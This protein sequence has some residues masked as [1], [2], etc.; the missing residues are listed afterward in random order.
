[1]KL[2]LLPSDGGDCIMVEAGGVAILADGGMFGSYKDEVRAFLGGFGKPL[3]LV[4]VSHVDEDH[5]AGVLQMLEDMVAWRVHKHKKLTNP[6]AKAPAF[7]E[8]PAVKRIWHNA[9]KAMVDN[10]GDV[11]T[12]LA[13]SANTLRSAPSPALL[14]LGLAYR[15]IANSIPQAVKVSRRIASDQLNIPLNGEF[16]GL[17][18]MVRED[19]V[20]KLKS[21]GKLKIR[22][23]GPF[24]EDLEVLRD[25]WDEWL[26]EHASSVESLQTWLDKNDEP[27][28]GLGASI[29]DEL[30]KRSKVT[31]PNLASLMLLL[32]EKVGNRIIR[33][34]MTG[35][36]HSDDVMEGLR[37]HDRLKDG[38]GLHVDVMKVP[39]HGSEHNLNRDFVKRITADHYVISGVSGEHHNPD[40]RVLQ[41]IAESRL[42]TADQ[43][44]PNPQ[45][46]N[47]F[48][49]WI[50][51]SSTYLNAQLA[52]LQAG[53]ATQSAKN[54]VQRHLDH[55]LLIEADLN[56]YAA[57]SGGQMQVQYL[58]NGPLV[59]NV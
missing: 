9:F 14:K 6:N 25:Y 53:G 49:V 15:S 1:M 41:V 39:H 55:M 4:Y 51:C 48:T 10:A 24:L 54:A 5:I 43:L 45:V 34:V 37:H 16:D 46:G 59:L 23:I 17:L 33:V 52:A 35:D 26:E 38:Q 44:S 27:L 12:M 42:G 30:G 47:N 22:V 8:P 58:T 19:D 21:D 50:N 11:G 36:G 13:S 20:I 57:N 40:L 7:P 28:P 56:D 2:T 31:E 18:G 29:D 3:D 32:E